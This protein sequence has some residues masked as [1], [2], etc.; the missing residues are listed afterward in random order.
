M[1]KSDLLKSARAG[2]LALGLLLLPLTASVPAQNNDN[3]NSGATTTRT[4]TREER[5]DDRR[6]EKDRDWGWLGLFGLAG[7]LGL[8]PRKRVPIVREAHNPPN[9]TPDVNNRR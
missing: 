7:L 3:N 8:I 6:E 4:E 9:P 5:R 1:K 2:A